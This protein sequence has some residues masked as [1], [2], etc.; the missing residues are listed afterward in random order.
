MDQHKIDPIFEQYS[1]NGLVNR[2]LIE[3]Y[4]TLNYPEYPE[5]L[6]QRILKFFGQQ[7]TRSEA[8]QMIYTVIN[9]QNFQDDCLL[10]FLLTDVDCS[11]QVDAD[12][13]QKMYQK[14]GCQIDY[15]QIQQ[16]VIDYGEFMKLNF[17]QYYELS[18]K[19]AGK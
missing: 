3:Q 15:E 12:E 5:Q 11:G 13:L 7:L 16:W 18:K 6:K 17:Y 4:I 10:Y 2:Q 19:L 14:M 1:Q 9:T 8:V